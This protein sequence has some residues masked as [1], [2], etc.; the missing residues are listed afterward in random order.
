MPQHF[1]GDRRHVAFAKG[2]ELKEVDDGIAFGPAEVGVRDG[3]RVIPTVQ[4]KGRDRVRDRGAHTAE[5]TVG[6]HLRSG[7]AQPIAERGGVTGTDLEE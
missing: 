1:A 5:H 6:S 3:P 7:D 2:Q 4:Q